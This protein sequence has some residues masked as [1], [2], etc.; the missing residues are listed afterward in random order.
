[1]NHPKS[2]KCGGRCACAGHGHYDAGCRYRCYG[3][4]AHDELHHKDERHALAQP[5]H[6]RPRGGF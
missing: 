3:S 6:S 1:M 2:C 5:I 4:P